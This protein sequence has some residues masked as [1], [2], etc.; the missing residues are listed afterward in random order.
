MN[1]PVSAHKNESLARAMARLGIR[2]S[3]LEESFVR[4][5]GPGGQNVNKVSTCVVLKHVPSGL[6]I[7]CQKDRSQA[8]NR[9]W[10][11]RIL[12]DRIESQILGRQSEEARR[13]A[14]IK[15][16]KRKR[17]KRAKDKILASKHAH[18]QKK[19][20]RRRVIEEE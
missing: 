3:D 2:D 1:F 20:L 19:Q 9:Y 7:K 4:S 16:Q 6:V 5:G 12:V 11:R 14:K 13:I 15:R 18:G 8:M 17:S 10:A